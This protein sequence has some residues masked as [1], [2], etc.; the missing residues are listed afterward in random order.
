LTPF[1]IVMDHVV[2][3][4]FVPVSGFVVIR[5]L[6]SRGPID[7]LSVYPFKT[8]LVRCTDTRTGAI[9]PTVDVALAGISHF[10]M[11]YDQPTFHQACPQNRLLAPGVG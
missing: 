7:T 2:G 9:L 11:G 1:E 8:I 10:R 3:A 4:L 5:W 6:L